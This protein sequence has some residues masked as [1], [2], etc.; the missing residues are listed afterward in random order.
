MR[1]KDDITGLFR[2]R[3][4]NAGMEV[5]EGFWE[6]LRQDLAPAPS[7]PATRLA[8]LF[9]RFHRIAAAASVAL[10]L[11]AASAA[12]WYFSPEEEIQEAFT[13]VA[14][15][16]SEGGLKG[17][18]VQE[19]FPSIHQPSLVAQTPGR[20]MQPVAVGQSVGGDEAEGEETV[21]LR[22][23]ITITQRVYGADRQP[24]GGGG[25]GTMP[26][27]AYQARTESNPVDAGRRDEAASATDNHPS[28]GQGKT[29]VRSSQWA[30]KAALGTA[31]PKGDCKMP[32][33]A[34]VTAERRLNERFSLEAGLQYDCLAGEQTLH[35]LAVPVK[36][37]VL[38][39]ATPKVDLYA[40]AGGAAEKCVAGA[41]DNGFKAEPVR[42]SVAAGVGVRYKLNDRFALFAEPSVSHHFGTD[43]HNRSLR[44]ERPTNLNLLCG[45]R[46]SY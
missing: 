2:D 30:L 16:T 18:A 34:T 15:L 3:L 41:T 37:N 44:T 40:T 4:A 45:L 21:S 46:M 17:D 20:G 5:R 24:G 25:W 19:H 33:T 9:L 11:G 28:G 12:F 38:L 1:E 22:V 29:A 42:L 26:N 6:E 8:P 14:T 13:Q 36:L 43:S 23:S 7:S 39:A 35:T 32:F 27:G 31:L 10:V